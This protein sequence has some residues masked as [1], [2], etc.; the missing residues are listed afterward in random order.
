MDSTRS[1]IKQLDIVKLDFRQTWKNKQTIYGIWNDLEP[2]N[3][4]QPVFLMSAIVHSKNVSDMGRP[5]L[6]SLR[7]YLNTFRRL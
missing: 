5:Y 3:E 7:N 6:S 2:E 4:Q 1:Y